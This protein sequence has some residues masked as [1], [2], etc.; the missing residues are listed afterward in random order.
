MLGFSCWVS[1][2]LT[3]Q[4]LGLE[5]TTSDSRMRIILS[6]CAGNYLA[7]GLSF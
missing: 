5:D 2:S 4:A 3:S 6:L 1:M 7:G